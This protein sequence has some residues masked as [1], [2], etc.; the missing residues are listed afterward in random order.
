MLVFLRNDISGSA[1]IQIKIFA[2]IC[3][4][5]LLLRKWLVKRTNEP[6]L[7]TMKNKFQQC[8]VKRRTDNEESV[9]LAI[10]F[11]SNHDS[12]FSVANKGSTDWES[13][14]DSEKHK[15]NRS[16]NVI[17]EIKVHYQPEH[18]NVS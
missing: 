18:K 1:D 15:N 17:K 16:D 7:N 10:V 5:R 2:L 6:F 9:G 12:I 8:F 13:D 3:S 11:L 4:Y 14:V